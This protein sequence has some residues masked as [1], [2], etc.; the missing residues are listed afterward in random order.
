MGWRF[1]NSR[2]ASLVASMRLGFTSVACMEPETSM[3]RM[4]VPVLCG[5]SIGA[6][7]RARATIIAV[8]ASR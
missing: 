7:G 8:K 6:C 2:A 3:E 1:T 5:T 4:T